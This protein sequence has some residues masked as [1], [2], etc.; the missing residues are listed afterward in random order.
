[1]MNRVALAIAAAIILAG[2]SP[3]GTVIPT[4]PSKWDQLSDKAKGLSDDDRRL[5][6]AYLIR[7]SVGAA[8]TGGKPN[9]PPGTTIGQAIADQKDFVAD[10]TKQAADADLLA[11]KAAAQRAAAEAAL[12]KVALVT[13]ISKTDRPADPQAGRFSENVGLVI[14]VQNKG[15]KDIA[16]IKGTFE[17]DDMFG[18]LLKQLSV[19]MDDPIKAGQIFSTSNYSMDVNQ[20]ENADVRLA[21]TDLSKL[22]V[23]FH[24]DMIVFA[25]GTQMAAPA[26]SVSST[27]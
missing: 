10:Q 1:M 17:F 16:G 26:G 6:A 3:K 9:I 23:T 20:F 13:I 2:C 14:A 15:A 25:D 12:S 22:K 24:P 19:S 11:A 8:L 7:E 21:Q 18:T 27:P 5:L 4:D